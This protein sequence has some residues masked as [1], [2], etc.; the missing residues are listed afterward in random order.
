MALRD[1]GEDLARREQPVRREELV[2]GA[3][4]A[5]PRARLGWSQAVAAARTGRSAT[6]NTSTVVACP[7]RIA[8]TAWPTMAH[9]ATPPGPTSPQYVSS[10]SAERVGEVVVA[11]R[12]SMS[13]RTMPSMSLRRQPGVVDGGQRR[14]GGEGQVAAPG[15]AGEVGGADADDR[16]PVAVVELVADAHRAPPLL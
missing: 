13:Q 14:L 8:P 6:R 5:D 7:D 10:S 9:G 1:Q 16:A 11:G 15:V 3:G 12:V 4:A 2:V